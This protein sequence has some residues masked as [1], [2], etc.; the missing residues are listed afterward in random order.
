MM[1][2]NV[3]TNGGWSAND[4]GRVCLSNLQNRNSEKKPPNLVQDD[5]PITKL[6]IRRV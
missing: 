2:A 4:G 1:L 5:S 6:V 3:N